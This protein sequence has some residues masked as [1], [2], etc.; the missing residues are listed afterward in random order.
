MCGF[1]LAL[2]GPG[3]SPLPPQAV[4]AVTAA[5]GH[6]SQGKEVTQAGK[7]SRPGRAS[8]AAGLQGALHSGPECC[9]PLCFPHT[10]TFLC[11]RSKCPYCCRGAL[12]FGKHKF[13]VALAVKCLRSSTSQL[14]LQPC[15]TDLSS[16]A[17]LCQRIS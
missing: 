7:Q 8:A 4:G 15:S 17:F 14:W 11:P 3:L 5:P 16:A 6:E 9:S 2:T 1:Q 13:A 12:V 10:C